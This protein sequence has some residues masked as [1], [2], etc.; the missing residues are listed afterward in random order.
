MIHAI[1]GDAASKTAENAR[2]LFESKDEEGDPSSSL[3]KE[4]TGGV[5][6]GGRKAFPTPN[7]NVHDAYRIFDGA[8]AMGPLEIRLIVPELNSEADE[9]ETGEKCE[10]KDFGT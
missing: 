1:C 5:C 9:E 8:I 4:C 2:P 10:D 7:P 3:I 6:F